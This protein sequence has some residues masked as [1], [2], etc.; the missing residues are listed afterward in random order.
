M[1]ESYTPNNNEADELH[2]SWEN[3]RGPRGNLRE[4][5]AVFEREEDMQEAVD[6]L[7]C[8]GFSNAA[9]SRP[10]PIELIESELRQE[11]QTISE[12]E[13]NPEISREAY[14][15]P[16]SRT[17]GLMVL[18]VIPVYVMLLCGIALSH[19]Y[20]LPFA[21]GSMLTV[22]L[23]AV[24][25]SLGAYVAFR[26][27]ETVKRHRKKEEALGGFLL[28]VRTG[29]VSQEQKA[30]DILKAHRGNDVHMHGPIGAQ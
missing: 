1:N 4:A 11:I 10:P 8:H 3:R 2:W 12:L 5:V 17:S 24:G 26:L 7:E 16:D 6:D 15:D 21:Y 23:G 20:G 18:I 25:G 14:I 22:S 9:I 28:W 13:D 19:A 29:N 27:N 30:V